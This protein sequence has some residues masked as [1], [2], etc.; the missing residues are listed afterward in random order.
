MGIS[1]LK[2]RRIN[3]YFLDNTH[4]SNYWS[5]MNKYG[6]KEDQDPQYESNI[7]ITS[8]PSIFKCIKLDKLDT[9]SGPL[10]SL[11]EWDEEEQKHV[12]SA[13][14][15]TGSTTQLATAG[16]SLYNGYPIGLDDFFGSVASDDL[17]Q[18]FVQA[19]K[20]RANKNHLTV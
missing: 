2:V 15:L 11:M 16:V 9:T 17:F 20:I 13:P 10:F 3:M 7:Y 18:V 4:K 6:L 19:C 8:V 12:F 5:L 14:A 1:K